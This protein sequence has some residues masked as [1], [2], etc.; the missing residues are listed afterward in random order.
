ML[1]LLSFITAALSLRAIYPSQS[2][3][4]SKR[5]AH[6]FLAKIYLR[7]D[8]VCVGTMYRKDLAI[9]TATYMMQPLHLYSVNVPVA[10]K[11]AIV[12]TKSHILSVEINPGIRLSATPKHNLALVKLNRHESRFTGLRLDLMGLG[13][14]L[15]QFMTMFG[16]GEEKRDSNYYEVSVEIDMP[17]FRTKTCAKVHRNKIDPESELCAGYSI[18]NGDAYNFS[19]ASPLMYYYNSNFHLAGLYSWSETYNRE[20]YPIVFTRISSHVAWIRRTDK[21]FDN[22]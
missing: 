20:Y 16:W 7:D 12:Y 18:G 14:K 21:A 13:F 3:E 11:T 6:R 19:P 1:F 15:G 9:T 17:I 8:F 4:M 5:S 2:A 22:I 10:N